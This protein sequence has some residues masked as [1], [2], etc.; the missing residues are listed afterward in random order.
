MV[1][2]SEKNLDVIRLGQKVKAKVRSFPFETFYGVVT[3]IAHQG[4]KYKSRQVFYIT[5]KIAN[6]ELL[7]KPGMTGQAKIYCGKRNIAYLLLRR[8]VRWI[9]IEVWSWF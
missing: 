8:I 6:P 1:P 2:V 5:S 7:L 3:R 9:R 4:E